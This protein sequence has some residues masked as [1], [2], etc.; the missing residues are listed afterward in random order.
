MHDQALV[1]NT[2]THL[3]VTSLTARLRGYAGTGD[4]EDLHVSDL[5]GPDDPLSAVVV[6]HHWALDGE[7]IA[8]DAEVRDT[9]YRFELEPLL[10]P[11][12]SI[13]GVTGRAVE[14]QHSPGFDERTLSAVERS[15]C[16]GCWSEDLRTGLTSV[17]EGLAALLGV[18]RGAHKHFDIRVF[19]HPDD[20]ERIAKATRDA[21]GDDL[22][23]C[24]HRILCNGSRI[25]TV[26]E[27]L[28]IMFDAK[29]IPL[30]RIGT[31]QDISDLKEREAELEELA[32]VDSLTR[33]PNRAAFEE[34]LAS[35]L[36]RA[37]RNHSRCALLFID[38]DD[39]KRVND[40]HGH[41]LGDRLLC[42][43]ADRLLRH[44]R[45]SD[46]V[47]RLAGDE[48]VILIEDLY[49]DDAALDAGRKILRSLESEFSV[50]H[51]VVKLCASIGI[52][53][54]PGNARDPRALLVFADREMYAV[55]RAGGNGVRLVRAQEESSA[56][57]AENLVCPAPS[58][59][60]LPHFASAES[61]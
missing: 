8:F 15:A 6:A 1:W 51:A 54:Y 29:G 34:C 27:R 52:A 55:K 39:F 36:A 38:L 12:G 56:S 25:R 44:V 9:A 33:L 3:Q 16:I 46:T 43:V 58:S 23:A 20:R 35:G 42:A 13:V 50:G 19:D 22:F 17:S 10:D 21:S 41:A 24:D 2:N 60:N 53:T 59:A 30:A 14:Q 40:L 47:C 18:E 4:G 31:L 32:L 45:V 61:V 48:F 28:R 57:G 7:P 5:W 37:A 26:R 49:T 11:R